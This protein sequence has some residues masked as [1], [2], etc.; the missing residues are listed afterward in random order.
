MPTNEIGQRLRELRIQVGLTLDEVGKRI[1][2]SKQA[3]YKYETGITTNIPLDKIEE[4]AKL[5]RVSPAEIMG[6]GDDEENYYH[7]P[8]AAALADMIKDN[9][10]YRVLFEASRNLSADDVNFVIDMIKKL[11]KTDED[12]IE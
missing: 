9:P 8:E 4:L 2:V 1:G 11:A 5:Y 3:I 10:R 6:W 7:D 12:F